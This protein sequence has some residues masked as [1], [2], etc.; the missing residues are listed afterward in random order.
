MAANECSGETAKS[1][2]KLKEIA[3][4]AAY[5]DE[6]KKAIEA[7]AEFETCGVPALTEIAKEATFSDERKLAIEKIS[8]AMSKAKTK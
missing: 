8:E 4:K 5:C 6:R 1:V 7:L 2:E 3:L